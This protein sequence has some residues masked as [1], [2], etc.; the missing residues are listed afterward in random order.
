MSNGSV[1]LSY[2]HF[3]VSLARRVAA[4]LTAH[5]YDVW[6]DHSLVAGEDFR[7][8]IAHKIRDCAALVVVFTQKSVHSA[9][10][11][12]E[13]G[14]ADHMNKLVPVLIGSAEIPLGFGRRHCCCVRNELSDPVGPES[15]AI[16]AAV[17]RASRSKANSFSST[18]YDQAMSS[19]EP[20]AVAR[21]D[22]FYVGWLP[23]KTMLGQ[24]LT[25]APVYVVALLVALLVYPHDLTAAFREWIRLLHIYSGMIVFAGGLFLFFFLRL[26]DRQP[27]VEERVS[28]G[29][30][31]RPLLG[32]WRFAAM[33]QLL[34]GVAL[35]SV[36][37][38]S[39]ADP[40]LGQ[41]IAFYLMALYVWWQGFHAAILAVESEALYRDQKTVSEFRWQR[42][43]HIT[44]A[45]L[46]TAWTLTLMVYKNDADI[47][48]IVERLRSIMV[49]TTPVT[50]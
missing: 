44:A 31:V 18:L 36:S 8:E 11:L 46:L 2:S 35:I 20:V 34:T 45:L 4:L 14:R 15:H 30:V 32:G 1:F 50:T 37:R 43:V 9:W 24:I 23:S 25:I 41:A 16:V 12:D 21:P 10:V 40:W 5:G 19:A 26:S 48:A 7:T 39:L 42:D 3:D 38:Y 13:A 27:T 49:V 29:D 17:E 6:W 28:A 22:R 47:V 33:A